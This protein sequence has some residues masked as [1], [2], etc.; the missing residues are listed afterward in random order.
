MKCFHVSSLNLLLCTVKFVLLMTFYITN[1]GMSI[2]WIISFLLKIK[3]MLYPVGELRLKTAFFPFSDRKSGPGQPCLWKWGLSRVSEGFSATNPYKA[4]E[5]FY[6]VSAICHINPFLMFSLHLSFWF[7]VANT[8]ITGAVYRV[9]FID[10][11][12]IIFYW[13]RHHWA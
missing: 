10:L 13:I 8:E 5:F 11:L 4:D 12:A 2:Q 3:K 6:V 9:R 7:L 1:N